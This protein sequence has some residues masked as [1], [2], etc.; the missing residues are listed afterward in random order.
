MSDEARYD[1]VCPGQPGDGSDA[2]GTPPAADPCAGTGRTASRG[3]AAPVDWLTGRAAELLLTGGRVEPADARAARAADRLARLLAAAGGGADPSVASGSSGAPGQDTSAAPRFAGPLTLDP[4]REEAALAAFRAA[5]GSSAVRRAAVSWPG[6]TRR[7][8]RM[9]FAAAASVVAL[10]GVAVAVAATGGRI[11]L[12]GEGS[13]AAASSGSRASAPATPGVGE[14]GHSTGPLSPPAAPDSP[15]GTA[16]GP[17][18]ATG[19]A[20]PGFGWLPWC[21]AY[22]AAHGDKGAAADPCRRLVRAQKALKDAQKD[23]RKNGKDMDKGFVDGTHRKRK[24]DSAWRSA[25]PRLDGTVAPRNGNGN[26]S[27]AGKGDD[28][29]GGKGNTVGS[30]HGGDGPGHGSGTTPNRS[31][32]PAPTP[33]PSPQAGSGVPPHSVQALSGPA[34]GAAGNPSRDTA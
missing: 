20:A 16:T 5:Y 28:R 6:P 31:I 1:A 34:G 14:A 13:A 27:G 10:S 29:G 4:V 11:P 8:L 12:T 7:A 22:L 17:P 30:G 21:Q 33:A 23:G 26:G 9:S 32:H 2:P 19:S 3:G 25:P 18:T 24:A 15:P